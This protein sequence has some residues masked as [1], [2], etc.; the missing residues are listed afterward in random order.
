MSFVSV[1]LLVL[2]PPLM[3]A[4]RR[5]AHERGP[6]SEDAVRIIELDRVLFRDDRR[7]QHRLLRRSRSG[8]NRH[9]TVEAGAADLVGNESTSILSARETDT[10][11][12]SRPCTSAAS[13]LVAPDLP[14]AR[15]P[16]RWIF[17]VGRVT[18]MRTMGGLLAPRRGHAFCCVDSAQKVQ[19]IWT[20][21]DL[22]A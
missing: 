21:N 13:T 5:Q 12:A 7:R 9:Q 10:L 4:W 15:R 1:R 18:P 11:F 2:S 22:K 6:E 17:E 20:P 3:R 14:P 19:E 16:L 8:E